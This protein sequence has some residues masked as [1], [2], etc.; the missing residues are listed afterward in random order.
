MA[1]VRALTIQGGVK[2]QIADADTLVVGG[3]IDRAS[4]AVLTI[5]GAN[6]TDVRIGRSGQLVRVMGDLQVDGA[7]TVLGASVFEQ[8]A[9]FEGNVQLGDSTADLITFAGLINGDLIFARTPGSY[10]TIRPAHELTDGQPGTG[11]VLSGNYAGSA[12][13]GGPGGDGGEVTVRGGGGGAG[14]FTQAAGAGGLLRLAGGDAGTSGAGGDASAGHVEIDGGLG[15]TA[16]LDGEVRIASVA[17]KQVTIADNGCDIYVGGRL[18]TRGGVT[19]GAEAGAFEISTLEN[20]NYGVGAGYFHSFTVGGTEYLYVDET[21]VDALANLHAWEGAHVS[22]SGAIAASSVHDVLELYAFRNT[23]SFLAGFGTGLLFQAYQ[24]PSVEVNLARVAAVVTSAT[25][26][27]E[28]ASLNL[29]TKASGSATLNTRL[30][31]MGTGAVWVGDPG[32]EV[33]STAGLYLPNQIGMYGRANG[34]ASY[35]RLLYVNGSTVTLFGSDQANSELHGSTAINFRTGNTDRASIL[36]SGLV[37][38]TTTSLGSGVVGIGLANAASVKVLSSGAAWHNMATLTSG[39]IFQFGS[40][41]PFEVYFGTRFSVVNGS[42]QMFSVRDDGGVLVGTTTALGAVGIGLANN[43]YLKGHNGTSWVVIGGVATDTTLLGNGSLRTNIYGSDS[44]RFAVAAEEKV[45]FTATAAIFGAYEGRA[46]NISAYTVRGANA[47]GTNFQGASVILAT[48]A[49]TG[50]ATAP[51]LKLQTAAVGA[52]GSTVQTLNDVITLWGDRGVTIGTNHGSSPVPGTGGVIGLPN[53]VNGI[54]FRNGADNAWLN[55]MHLQGANLLVIGQS[56]SGGIVINAAGTVQI[57]ASGSTVST[58]TFSS[59]EVILGASENTGTINSYL[60]RGP[61]LA[62]SVTDGAAKNLTYRTAI[63]TGAGAGGNHI[64]EAA[65]PGAAGNSNQSYR[66]VLRLSGYK[67]TFNG[68]VRLPY[69]AVTA[70]TSATEVDYWVSV[71]TT[72]GAVTVTLPDA[73]SVGAGFELIV[74]DGGGNAAVNNITVATVL[75]QTIDGS[76]TS[77]T[78]STARGGMGLISTGSNWETI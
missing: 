7:E 50:N 27:Q 69:R 46:T 72:G 39:N 51:T 18:L 55:G 9:V 61:V 45:R 71:D 24:F 2:T 70:D 34:S 59:A 42:T 32:S 28:V 37:V 8:D 33:P 19:V 74:K 52:S 57:R 78:I 53:G 36:D 30:S 76:G 40:S 41:L 23:S 68:G 66:E 6:A 54:A 31:V 44:I 15:P 11:L 75:S 67:A 3:G 35:R 1:E 58:T 73:G 60:L 20:A 5:G 13:A 49:G 21:T 65:I 47:S 29:Q 63:G 64:F 56:T 77:A 16:L 48:G 12:T 62:T 25:S 14:S 38:G 43:A 10:R 26:G 22:L 17:A 4:G